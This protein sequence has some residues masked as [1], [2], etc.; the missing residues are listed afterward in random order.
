MRKSARF[1]EGIVRP[2][3]PNDQRNPK[4]LSHR[5]QWLKLA[6]AIGDEMAKKDFERL[7]R[8]RPKRK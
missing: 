4:H 6:D 3:E 1:G 5:E 8:R 7:H 2:L